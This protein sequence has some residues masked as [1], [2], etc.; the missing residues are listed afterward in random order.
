MATVLLLGVVLLAYGY[1]RGPAAVFYA[2]LVII[3][4]GLV[5]GIVQLVG[6]REL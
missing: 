2:A 1:F 3:V 5:Y 4:G 6:R